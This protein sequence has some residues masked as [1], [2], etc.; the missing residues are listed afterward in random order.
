MITRGVLLEK[1]QS[2]M[3]KTSHQLRIH[4]GRLDAKFVID[5]LIE[6]DTDEAGTI[7]SHIPSGYDG[8]INRQS[9]PGSVEYREYSFLVP[10]LF[11]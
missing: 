9:E 3:G 1:K 4:N 6:G 7:E 8:D 5:D 11:F 10:F 2:V